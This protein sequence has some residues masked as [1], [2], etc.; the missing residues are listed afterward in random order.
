[1]KLPARY[2]AVVSPLL[3]SLLMTCLVSLISTLRSVGPVPD[4]LHVWLGAWSI[5]W[6]IAFPTML[7]LLPLVRRA[8]RALVRSSPS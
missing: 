5:S 8:T 3:L 1:M 7:A 6:L 2:A 4:L